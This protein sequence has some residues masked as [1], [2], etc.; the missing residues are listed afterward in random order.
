MGKIIISNNKVVKKASLEL[1]KAFIVKKVNNPNSVAEK[2][3]TNLPAIK[4]S[5]VTK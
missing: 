2:I 3:E 5:P 4:K 1:N